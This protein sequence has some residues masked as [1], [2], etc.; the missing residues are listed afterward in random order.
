MNIA[1]GVHKTD[2][3]AKNSWKE[4]NLERKTEKL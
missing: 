1:S 4:I 3:N 2:S